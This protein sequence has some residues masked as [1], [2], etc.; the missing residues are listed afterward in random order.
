MKIN[1][2]NPNVARL[3]S[4]GN[5]TS[6][7]SVIL[8]TVF[9]DKPTILFNVHLF[10]AGAL[11]ESVDD[12]LIHCR[13]DARQR[14]DK[15]LFKLTFKSPLV[16]IKVSSAI[17]QVRSCSLWNWSRVAHWLSRFAISEMQIEIEQYFI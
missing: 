12:C 4:T 3:R 13:M 5:A 10:L 6:G 11:P 9:P 16:D 14:L 17:C 1:K 7:H 15:S 2:Q 8:T